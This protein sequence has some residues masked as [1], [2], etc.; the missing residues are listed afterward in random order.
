MV[1]VGVEGQLVL[2]AYHKA[3]ISQAWCLNSLANELPGFD[4][5]YLGGHPPLSPLVL[6]SLVRCHAHIKRSPSP[7]CWCAMKES[8]SL[9][10]GNLPFRGGPIGAKSGPGQQNYSTRRNFRNG[11]GRELWFQYQIG[12]GENP[13]LLRLSYRNFD[14]LLNLQTLSFPV[15]QQKLDYQLPNQV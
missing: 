10:L 1:R 6:R 9:I 13:V 7:G 5:L 12:Q 3:A 4:I 2:S 15:C 11:R 14:Q 8:A